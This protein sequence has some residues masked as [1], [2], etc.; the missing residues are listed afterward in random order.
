[1]FWK[2]VKH[3]KG[4]Q[5]RDSRW[6]MVVLT[7]AYACLCC[8]RSCNPL[9]RLSCSAASGILQGFPSSCPRPTPFRDPRRPVVVVGLPT[10]LLACGSM[11]ARSRS[12]SR[13]S[14]APESTHPSLGYLISVWI[15]IPYTIQRSAESTME[16][17]VTVTVTDF[18]WAHGAKPAKM[19]CFKHGHP[20]PT[21]SSI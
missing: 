5:D 16:V 21:P 3:S 19:Q 1:M 20:K 10:V 7:T 18:P 9:R 17:S 4:S 8:F 14:R 2:R 15:P 6:V 11:R 12:I 13:A